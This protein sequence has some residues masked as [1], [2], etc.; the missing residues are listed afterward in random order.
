MSTAINIF[1]AQVASSGSIPFLVKAYP[2]R[3]A[4]IG[5]WEGKI[6]MR[7]DCGFSQTP[8]DRT[9]RLGGWEGEIIMAEDFKKPME[10]FDSE[11]YMP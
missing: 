4:R 1:L 9:V 10:E 7:D 5:G 2:N 8:A 11:E 6:L 3:A